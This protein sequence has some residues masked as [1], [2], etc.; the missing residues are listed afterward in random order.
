MSD[1]H[2][3]YDGI[4]YKA[5]DTMPAVFKLLLAGLLIWGVCF[6]GYYLF[7]GWSSEGEF[8]Q[9]KAQQ[10]KLIAEQQ[11][12]QQ[13][14]AAAGGHKEGKLADYIAYGKKEYAARCAACHGA[15]AKGGIGPDLTRKEF[16]YGRTEQ[17]LTETIASGRPGGMPGFSNELSHEKIERS[18]QIHPF[19][20]ELR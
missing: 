3:E 4:S 8:A 16:K 5:D 7:S 17:A 20:V 19:V 14:Q 1:N 11:K 10:E 6:M 2:K 15:D 12:A 9:K 18:G 13:S